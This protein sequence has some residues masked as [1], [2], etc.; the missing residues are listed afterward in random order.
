MAKRQKRRAER[1]EGR[2]KK[3]ATAKPEKGK[4]SDSSVLGSRRT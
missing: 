1:F 4:N 3:I 2:T